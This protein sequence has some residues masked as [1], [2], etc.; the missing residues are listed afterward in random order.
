VR[1]IEDQEGFTLVELLVT[2]LLLT[3]VL[4]ATLNV[5]DS[6]TSAAPAE[7]EWSHTMADTQTAAYRMTREL[8]Q[9]TTLSLIT[10]YVV[11]ADIAASGTTSHVLY[12]CD[13]NSSCTRKASTASAPTRGAGGEKLI[14]AVQNLALSSPVFTQAGKYFQ[15]TLKVRS[16]STLTTAHAHV[17]TYS[18]G[19]L[20]RNL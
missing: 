8:R 16:A 18:D 10:P 5:L 11:S 3:I 1:L 14:G 19:F 4:G 13:L 15:V 7:Q 20:A 6:L 2:M 12:E 9:A 17:M